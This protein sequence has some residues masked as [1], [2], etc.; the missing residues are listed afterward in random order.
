MYSSLESARDSVLYIF[1][2]F[3]YA[4]G[5]IVQIQSFRIRSQKK[6]FNRHL[7]FRNVLGK[8]VKVEK[9]DRALDLSTSGL[10]QDKPIFSILQ[11]STAL[12]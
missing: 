6:I 5:C 11:V 12:M 8:L 7:K 1:F 2:I 3:Q 4:K 9:I 10:P